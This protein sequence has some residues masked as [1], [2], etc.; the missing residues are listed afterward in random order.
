MTDKLPPIYFYIP[1]QQLP[2]D[3]MPQSPDEYWQWMSAWGSRYGRG[4]YDWTLQTYLHL[5]GDGLPC[6][7]IGEIPKS[8]IVIAHYD[9]FP[10][11]L[12]PSPTLLLVCIKVDRDPHPYAQLQ[13]VQNPDDDLFKR[14]QTLWQTY[15]I[16]FWLQP[17]LIKRDPARGSR[18]ENVS[19]YGV[20]GTLAPEL[21]E[22][23]WEQQLS[24]LGL[25]W[26]IID[27][28]RWHDYSQ[29]DVV[30]AVRSFDGKPYDSK[31]PSKLINAWHAGVPAILGCESAYRRE[32]KSELDYIE[33][34]SVSETI[35][36]LKR[37]RDDENLRHA[38]I[39]NAKIRAEE[40]SNA[41]LNAQWR[42][43]LTD[44]A[45]PAYYRWY[46]A[47][48]WQRKVFLISRY[49]TLKVKNT[50]NRLHQLLSDLKLVAN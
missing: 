32:R 25:R 27:S 7:L 48:S 6:E 29:T 41:S 14:S 13:I 43:F 2:L 47:Y 5:K 40:T 24:A 1:K 10:N 9:F 46:K 17:G 44:V 35:T 34:A 16:R 42:H 20:T 49:L 8:G 26:N 37:L 11:N 21:Q 23:V 39:E 12:Q 22:P 4:K 33:V 50:K 15:S 19:F 31:P 18:F 45:T 38:M 36:A 30:V 28:N 3:N